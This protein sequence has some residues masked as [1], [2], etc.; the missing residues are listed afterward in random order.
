[1][2]RTQQFSSCKK[3]MHR[4]NNPAENETHICV[5]LLVYTV[6]NFLST[7]AQQTDTTSLGVHLVRLQLTPNLVWRSLLGPPF[8]GRRLVHA[9]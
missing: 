6:Y 5:Q 4:C 3:V 9:K 2:D 1:M 8:A 7:Q